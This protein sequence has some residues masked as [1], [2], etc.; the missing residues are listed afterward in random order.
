MTEAENLNFAQLRGS[1][2]IFE[3]NSYRID[4][5][6]F[7]PTEYEL[8]HYDWTPLRTMY[9]TLH[10]Y[11]N[12]QHSPHEALNFASDLA[13]TVECL[14][15][16]LGRFREYKSTMD[17]I[18]STL[19][20]IVKE[21]GCEAYDIPA[22]DTSD[23]ELRLTKS[24]GDAWAKVKAAI[25]KDARLQE[26]ILEARSASGRIMQ[27]YQREARMHENTAKQF[28][29]EVHEAGKRLIEM[30]RRLDEQAEAISHRDERI[31][32]LEQRV[33]ELEEV[34]RHGMVVEP[35]DSHNLYQVAGAVGRLPGG[36]AK[37]ERESQKIESQFAQHYPEKGQP[38]WKG[39][40]AEVSQTISENAATLQ[41]CT[42][43]N[44]ALGIIE[45]MNNDGA[46]REGV[47]NWDRSMNWAI[48]TYE[49]IRRRHA[50]FVRNNPEN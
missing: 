37:A 1:T 35:P 5:D 14:G 25:S 23:V 13:A 15:N 45:L 4:P 6:N 24:L 30:K 43:S 41:A 11:A 27:F 22:S 3:L 19:L 29:A 42:T 31:K 44:D 33:R 36:N 48:E 10:F 7:S 34:P 18:A 38:G 47:A 8:P 50:E 39:V 46:F 17:S 40:R 28:H 9:E 2:P 16:E 49:I 26:L 12:R 32:R 21:N 20:Q